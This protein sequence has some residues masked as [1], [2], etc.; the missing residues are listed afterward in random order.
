MNRNRTKHVATK[1]W[2]MLVHTEV[3]SVVAGCILIIELGQALS[4][5]RFVF[6]TAKLKSFLAVGM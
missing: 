1:T 4:L 3:L 5:R 2:W 6:T